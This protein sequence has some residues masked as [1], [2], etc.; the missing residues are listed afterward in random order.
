MTNKYAEG[1]PGKRYY[2]GCQIVDQ[3]EQIAID[4]ACQLFN[5]T[6]ANVQPHSGAQANMAVMQALLEPGDTFMGLDLSHGGH[7]SHGSPVN[8]S[9]MLYK[10][11][12]YHV[13]KETG[14]VD[15]DEMEK[16]ALECHP[17]LIIA[18]ASAYSRDWDYK[19]MREI[20]D[21]VGAVLMADV[22]HPA[23]L[24]AKGLPAWPQDPEGRDED[25]VCFDQQR[26]VPGHPRWSSGARHRLQGRCFRRSP[27]RRVHGVHPTGEKERRLHGQSLHG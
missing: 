3:S 10:P 1:Y 6:F 4:R 23:G 13:A 26:R 2:G 11:V 9:G 21:K 17:K 16:I 5:A 12:A 14:R 19:R 25:D 22:S 20:A 7:L 15:Y 8:A 24:I 27:Q 18:G